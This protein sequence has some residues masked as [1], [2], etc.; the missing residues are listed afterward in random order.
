ME[1]PDDPQFYVKMLASL[2]LGSGGVPWD[3]PMIFDSEALLLSWVR[4]IVYHFYN[5]NGQIRCGW[6]KEDLCSETICRLCYQVKRNPGLILNPDMNDNKLSAYLKKIM[7]SLVADFYRKK[8]KAKLQSLYRPDRDKDSE[9][10]T[11]LIPLPVRDYEDILLA[12]ES[13][14]VRMEA[15][16]Q[17][18]IHQPKYLETYTV[19]LHSGK[20]HQ[21]FADV[22]VSRHLIAFQVLNRKEGHLPEKIRESLSKAFPDE[23]YANVS[24]RVTQLKTMLKEFLKSNPEFAD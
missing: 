2:L 24:Q 1:T 22:S 8:K 11:L 19:L 20:Y 5:T 9:D 13:A 4:G 3:I 21:P 23:R 17:S 18:L 7:R 12:S 14:R 15:F 16:A 10:V 6:E